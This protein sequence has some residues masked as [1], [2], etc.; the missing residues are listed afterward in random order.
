MIQRGTFPHKES[1]E[2]AGT[3]IQTGVFGR[4]AEQW[5]HAGTTAPRKRERLL[6]PIGL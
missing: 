6:A 4:Q 2:I 5:S 3:E 1:P